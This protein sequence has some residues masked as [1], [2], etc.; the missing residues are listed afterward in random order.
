MFRFEMTS[1]VDPANGYPCLFIRI[2]DP[3][4][5]AV[6]EMYREYDAGIEFSK[7]FFA[8]IERGETVPDAIWHL[9][10]DDGFD[11]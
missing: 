7:L 6:W 2:E 3:E 9:L 8:E 11:D 1:T 10:P 4:T 5:G